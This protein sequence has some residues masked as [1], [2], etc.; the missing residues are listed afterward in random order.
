MSNSADVVVNAG[1]DFKELQVLNIEAAVVI[2]EK[3]NAGTL[4]NE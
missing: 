3:S 2:F 4:I 1:V